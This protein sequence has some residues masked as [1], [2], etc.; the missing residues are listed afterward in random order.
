M[1]RCSGKLPSDINMFVRFQWC[2]QCT[3]WLVDQLRTGRSA[4][5]LQ[6]ILAVAF[7]LVY[8]NLYNTGTLGFYWYL[9]LRYGLK[10]KISGIIF[11]WMKTQINNRYYSELR[12]LFETGL[13]FSVCLAKGQSITQW[14]VLAEIMTFL[15]SYHSSVSC[16]SLLL[17]FQIEF[18]ILLVCKLQIILN[19]TL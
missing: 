13:F 17:L 10:W 3:L 4:L 16:Q 12:S 15:F 6:I 14:F 11:L 7:L 5:N 18:Q 8:P 9:I 2:Y 1:H 19:Y